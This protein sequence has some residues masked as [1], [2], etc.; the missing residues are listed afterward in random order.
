MTKSIY[1]QLNASGTV[2]K[3]RVVETFSGSILDTDRWNTTFNGNG[4]TAMADEVDGGLKLTSSDN[5]SGAYMINFNDKRQYSNSGCECIFVGKR[6]TT[7]NAQ[8]LG[9]FSSSTAL[10]G[11][12]IAVKDFTGNT[13][14]QLVYAKNGSWGTAINTTVAIDVNFHN[15]KITLSSSSGT[16]SIDGLTAV[17]NSS[18]NL[19]DSALQPFFYSGE[20]SGA[21]ASIISQ[22][23]YMECY[24]T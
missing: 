10:T 1:D 5:A 6:T 22:I 20:T 13:Y 17:T 7:T 19:P 2:A 16:L 8:M 23:R 12:V 14:K 24:N 15:H 4:T 18:D 21:S 9:G 3:Q 11:D